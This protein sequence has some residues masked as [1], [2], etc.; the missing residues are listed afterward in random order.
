MHKQAQNLKT[1]S[2]THKLWNRT[3][4]WCISKTGWLLRLT[5]CT[6]E[7]FT[8]SR[9]RKTADQRLNLFLSHWGILLFDTGA[10]HSKKVFWLGYGFAVVFIW[11]FKEWKFYMSLKFCSSLEKVICEALWFWPDSLFLTKFTE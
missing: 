11:H 3:V 4:Q 2:G 6:H 10:N 1:I 5:N 7:I 8:S 9:A